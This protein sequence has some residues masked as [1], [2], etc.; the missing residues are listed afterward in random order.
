MSVPVNATIG[1]VKL[2]VQK[3]LGIPSAQQEL[4]YYGMQTE[5]QDSLLNNVFQSNDFD[6]SMML[7][8]RAT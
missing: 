8:E 5:N 3:K 2:E 6:N 1:D 4:I 7:V